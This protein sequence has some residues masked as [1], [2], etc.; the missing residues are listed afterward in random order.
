MV[1][2]PEVTPFWSYFR[3]GDHPTGIVGDEDFSASHA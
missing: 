1:A 3:V 2:N